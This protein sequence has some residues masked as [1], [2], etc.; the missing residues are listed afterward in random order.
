VGGTVPSKKKPRRAR[1][2]S[3]TTLRSEKNLKKGEWRIVTSRGK[4]EFWISGGRGLDGRQKKGGMGQRLQQKTKWGQRSVEKRK[5]I[6]GRLEA[7]EG[8]Q[9]YWGGG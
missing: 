8:Y 4:Q 1:R 6:Q 2:T 5:E 7:R 3:E 9:S